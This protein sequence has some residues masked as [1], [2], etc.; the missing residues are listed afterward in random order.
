MALNS[1]KIISQLTKLGIS[2][3]L[4]TDWLEEYK[5]IKIEF[6]KKKWT[7]SIAAS[8][9][10]A[11]YTVAMLKE[12]Y[13]QTPVNQ[14]QIHF[15]SFCTDC[16]QMPKPNPEDEILLLAVP[17]AAKT[18]YTIRNKK[19]GSHVKAINPDYVDSLAASNIADYILSQFV[20]L[21]CKGTS[22]E[23]KELI[24]NIVQKK[25]SLVEE[26][27]DGTIKI[28]GG[29]KAPDKILLTLYQKGKR[30]TRKKLMEILQIKYQQLAD[31]SLRS[32]EKRDL[33]HGNTEGFAITS[34]GED[35]VEQI[36]QK[37]LKK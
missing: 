13:K 2:K 4:V 24:H 15:D 19:K 33:V 35:R 17:Y 8:G 27:E 23:V 1:K 37:S 6:L 30:L 34:L 36:V 11:E 16:I 20:L 25:V 18:I 5:K 31:T 21:K 9:L 7:N 32:L 22:S 26:F 28:Y 10:F 29:M 12:L 14:N 3:K